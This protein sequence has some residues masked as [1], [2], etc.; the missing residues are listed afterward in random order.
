MILLIYISKNP[1]QKTDL[2]RTTFFVMFIFGMILYCSCNY[3][4]LENA[5]LESPEKLHKELIWVKSEYSS[6]FYIP[7]VI[8]RSIIDVG[9]MFSGYPNGDAFYSLP[10]SRNPLF[11]FLFLLIN[12]VAFSTTAT[13]LIARFGNDLLRWVRIN[14]QKISDIILIFGVNDDSITLGRNIIGKKGDI[15]IYVD[16]GIDA[17]NLSLIRSMGGIAY[18]DNQALKADDSFLSRIR[19]QPGEIKLRLYALSDEYDKNLQYSLMMLDSLGKKNISPEQ[20]ELVLLGTAE[21]KGIIF[22]SS[23]NQY[24]Y[25]NVLSFD[26]YEMTAHLL[27]HE[28]PLCN[29]I[30]FDSDGRALEDINVLIIG[31]GRIGHEVLR[32]VVANGQFEGNNFCAAIYDPRFENRAGFVQFQYPKM[33]ENYNIRFEPQEG[34]STKI[35]SFLQEN[36][37]K[38]NYIVICIDDNYMTRGM[39]LRIVDRLQTLGY[40][41]NVYTCDKKSVRCYSQN[42]RG[43]EAHFIYDSDILFSEELNKYAVELNHKYLGGESII[44]DWKKCSYFD[45][46]S[47]LAAVDYLIPL[48]GRINAGKLTPEQRENL[49][50]SE[51][52]RWCAFLYSFGFDVM[53]KEEFI[54]RIKQRNQE[55]EQYGKSSIKLTKDMENFKHVCLVSWDE[56]DELSKIENS[57]TQGNIDYKNYDRQNI[58]MVMELIQAKFQEK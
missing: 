10:I 56:L 2:L 29:A 23:N 50:K 14:A 5:A 38:L 37:S 27:V 4:V 20:T 18:S 44:E 26:E 42:V 1:N 57:L 32:K 52:L 9:R 22:Q 21:S 13:A 45:R 49:S 47:S 3:L 6:L 39:A 28:Y 15:V 46:M 11:V 55:I 54:K 43:Y 40:S 17:K 41:K 33:F 58:D 48:I 31:F 35:F 24:G 19:V 30:N 51:H 25:G 7:Y 34:R 8:I 36:A 12:L 53:S 16:R